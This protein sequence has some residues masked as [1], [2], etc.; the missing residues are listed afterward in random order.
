[1]AVFLYAVKSPESKRQY[2]Q[3]LKCFLTFLI[4]QEIY[5]IRLRNSW[6]MQ[7]QI[8]SGFKI[9]LFNSFIKMKLLSEERYLYPQSRTITEQ[10]NYFERGYPIV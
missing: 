4:L 1:M 2:P 6:G 9:T 8:L 10:R 5:R 7:K 3:D